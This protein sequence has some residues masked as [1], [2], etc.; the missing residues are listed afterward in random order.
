MSHK[1]ETPKTQSELLIVCD[2]NCHW[3][4]YVREK[5]YFIFNIFNQIMGES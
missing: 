5:N 1:G 4:C 2:I 3:P